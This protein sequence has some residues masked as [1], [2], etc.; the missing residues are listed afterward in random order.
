MF[1]PWL[2]YIILIILGPSKLGGSDGVIIAVP[3]AVLITVISII[4]II[5]IIIIFYSKKKLNKQGKKKIAVEQ[6]T[7]Y[8]KFVHK[9][10]GSDRCDINN[11]LIVAKPTEHLLK[12]MAGQKIIIELIED[13]EKVSIKDQKNLISDFLNYLVPVRITLFAILVSLIKCQHILLSCKSF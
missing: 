7:D 1:Q 3:I 9:V 10:K 8:F 2:L 4:S 5:I 6:L 11:R 12:E 13:D